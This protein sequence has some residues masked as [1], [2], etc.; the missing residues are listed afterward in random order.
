MRKKLSPPDGK[1]GRGGFTL[2]E[3]LVAM[4]IF[5]LVVTMA[6]AAYDTTFKVVDNAEAGSEFSERARI[7]LSRFTE[8]V[9]S[10]YVHED[11]VTA[12]EEDKEDE[13]GLRFGEEM[14][15]FPSTAHV[16]FVKEEPPVGYGMISYT[17]EKE[18]TDG[19]FAL[20]RLETPFPGD[21]EQAGESEKEKKFLLCAGL[22]EVAFVYIDQY[23]DSHESWTIEEQDD[24]EQRFPVAVQLKLGFGDEQGE[25]TV[26]SFSTMIAIHTMEQEDAADTSPRQ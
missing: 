8:D 16:A 7:T 9:T 23:G 3:L 2:V 19:L 22:S 10:L 20:Y 26:A 21:G 14:L 1:S 15:R 11:A 12:K 13:A 17:V 5:S 4:V 6:F 18:E 25:E 24:R